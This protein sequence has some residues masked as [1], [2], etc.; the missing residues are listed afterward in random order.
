MAA[1]REALGLA[2]AEG[3]WLRQAGDELL[4][5]TSKG[6]GEPITWTGTGLHRL[7]IVVLTLAAALP[8]W[9]GAWTSVERETEAQPLNSPVRL[10]GGWLQGSAMVSAVAS[11]RPPRRGPGMHPALRLAIQATVASAAA[12][13]AGDAVDPNRFYW[14]M[15]GVLVILIGTYNVSEQVTKALF[16]TVGTLVGVLAGGL[17]AHAVG[18]RDGWAR[19]VV[20]IALTLA[21]YLVR[22]NYTFMIM[23]VTIAISQEY[24]QLGQFANH[25]LVIRLEETAIGAGIA[26]LVVTLVIPLYTRRVLRVAAEQHHAA[27]AAIAEHAAG[28]TGG[29]G[30]DASLRHA[31]RALD[32]AHHAMLATRRSLRQLGLLVPSAAR[33]ARSVEHLSASHQDARAPHRC[34]ACRRPAL[35]GR[36]TDGHRRVIRTGIAGTRA[37]LEAGLA[38]GATAPTGPARGLFG[39]RPWAGPCSSVSWSAP[40]RGRFRHGRRTARTPKPGAHGRRSGHCGR[41]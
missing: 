4:A 31:V 33:A 28:H 16:R 32:D 12:L 21:H 9:R 13:T 37:T 18:Q 15:I 35:P 3:E 30:G 1:L 5:W 2:P 36:G 19:A 34:R 7:S 22:V 8:R 11:A 39:P 40:V 14:A 6:A 27:A 20:L 41:R 29:H 10:A 17:L 38:V 24:V 23:G 25:L 26:A